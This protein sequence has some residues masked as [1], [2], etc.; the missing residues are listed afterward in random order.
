MILFKFVTMRLGQHRKSG[1]GHS[2]C[3]AKCTVSSSKNIYS[4]SDGQSFKA[5]LA[6]K[7]I[8]TPIN[9]SQATSM[10]LCENYF[11]IIERGVGGFQWDVPQAI[12]AVTQSGDYELVVL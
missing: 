3:V 1:T 10:S 8:A 5:A 2:C 6:A 12:G 11:L 9:Q 4:T 7:T